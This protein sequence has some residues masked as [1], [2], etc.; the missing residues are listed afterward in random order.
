MN[1]TLAGDGWLVRTVEVGKPDGIP[2][3]RDSTHFK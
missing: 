2:P 3:L 1:K